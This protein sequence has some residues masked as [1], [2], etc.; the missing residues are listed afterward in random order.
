M[1]RSQDL[2]FV[3]SDINGGANDASVVFDCAGASFLVI[4]CVTEAPSDDQEITITEGDTVDANDAT[5]YPA[6]TT[7]S[8]ATDTTAFFL[9]D[10]KG[11]RRYIKVTSSSGSDLRFKSI[12]GHVYRKG[13]APGNATEAGVDLRVF[14]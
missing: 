7:P 3:G 14:L 13:N 11:K 1:I 9:V 10:L 12:I 4:T 8:S 6:T 2:K 5:L